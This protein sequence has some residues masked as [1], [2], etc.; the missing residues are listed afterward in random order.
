MFVYC[1]GIVLHRKEMLHF[2]MHSTHFIYGYIASYILQRTTQ[3]VR[4]E[5][6]CCHHISYFFRIVAI[7]L[8]MHHPRQDSIYHSLSYTSH[9][10]LAGTRN[11]SMGHSKISGDQYTS[12]FYNTALCY[13]HVSIT[14]RI[15]AKPFWLSILFSICFTSCKNSD[16]E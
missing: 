10:A 13:F 15:I 4:D 14:K 5:T 16:T 1:T 12:K 6:F 2:T 11:S 3:A 9:G 8:L 7:G